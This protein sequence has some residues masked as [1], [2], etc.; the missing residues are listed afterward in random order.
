MDL[1][2]LLIADAIALIVATLV[3]TYYFFK[4][5]FKNKK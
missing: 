4:E 3:L 5:I 1:S 2:Y